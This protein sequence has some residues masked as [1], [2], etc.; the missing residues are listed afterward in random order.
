MASNAIVT[1][2]DEKRLAG[3]FSKPMYLNFAK[4]L[5]AQSRDHERY[6]LVILFGFAKGEIKQALWEDLRF[7]GPPPDGN[8]R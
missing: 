6:Y 3:N 5:V 7:D 2:S 4:R 8:A 1:R